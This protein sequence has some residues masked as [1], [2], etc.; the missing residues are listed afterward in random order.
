LNPLFYY[1]DQVYN[2]K[3][4]SFWTGNN[5]INENSDALFQTIAIEKNTP[6]FLFVQRLFNKTLSETDTKIAVVSKIPDSFLMYSMV[7][8][9]D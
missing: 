8:S 5:H 3:Y 2:Q 9:L 7:F 1:L 6:E 4:P